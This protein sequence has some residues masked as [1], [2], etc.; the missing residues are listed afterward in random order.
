M[1]DE[2]KEL[3]GVL[4]SRVQELVIAKG[5]VVALARFLGCPR[6]YIFQLRAGERTGAS[7][8]MLA[9]MGLRRVVRYERIVIPGEFKAAPKAA[10]KAKVAK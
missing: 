6:G 7:T 1:A 3:A 2:I 5:G 8:A 9:K 4:K 10:P